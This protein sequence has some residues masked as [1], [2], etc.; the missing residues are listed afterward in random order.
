M[1]SPRSS[2]DHKTARAAV[3][4]LHNALAARRQH[5]AAPEL[6]RPA[7]RRALGALRRATEHGP[8]QLFLRA[9]AV[10]VGDEAVMAFLPDDPPF[11]RL[12][13]AGIGEVVLTEGIAEAG[14]DEFVGRL[15]ALAASDDADAELQALL[16]TAH[17]SGVELR[18]E[19][20]L[21]DAGRESTADW[22]ALPPPLPTSAAVRAI[23][24]RDGAANLP[25]LAARQLLDDCEC[26]V[27]NSGRILQRLLDRMLA[28]G[29][30]KTITWLLTEIERQPQF[31]PLTRDRMFAQA[32]AHCDA[33][34]LQDRLDHGTTDELLELSALVM[35]LGDDIA[36]NFAAAAAAVAH[37]LTQWIGDLLG[38]RD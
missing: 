35:Q 19:A 13:A 34:W 11:G 32:R 37:P 38:T 18:A 6:W 31:D 28:A 4:S 23:V 21:P 22:S 8:L 29:D 9:G 17:V 24:E 3:Q 1:A 12:R 16:A 10:H 26:Q 27:P 7:H 36:E 15:H 30:V 20:D 25:A 5:P 33:A 2:N 14:V